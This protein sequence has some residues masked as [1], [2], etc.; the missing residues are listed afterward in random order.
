MTTTRTRPL[1]P[2]MQAKALAIVAEWLGTKL[3]LDGAAPTG[4]DAFRHA[5]GVI[6]DPAWEPMSGGAAR[7][8]ILG[9]GVYEEWAIWVAAERRDEFAA[10]GVFAEPIA[11]YALG[12]Y[13]P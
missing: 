6:L 4:L 8:T 10:I 12:L 2:T 1:T 3:G 9:E 7:P 13:R 5:T 11:S